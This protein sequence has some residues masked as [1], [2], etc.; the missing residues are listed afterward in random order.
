M[1]GHSARAGW[2]RSLRSRWA[3]LTIVPLLAGAGWLALRGLSRIE[4]PRSLEAKLDLGRPLLLAGGSALVIGGL[5]RPSLWSIPLLVIGL[6]VGVPAAVALV[7][8]GS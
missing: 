1:G 8:S 6:G 7:R 3:F 2:R 4:I 5:T